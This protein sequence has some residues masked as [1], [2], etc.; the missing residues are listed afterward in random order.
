M[1]REAVKKF[2]VKTGYNLTFQKNTYKKIEVICGKQKRRRED[3]P[4]RARR[5]DEDEEPPAPNVETNEEGRT[6]MP[7]SSYVTSSCRTC[8]SVDHNKRTCPIERAKKTMNASEGQSNGEQVSVHNMSK[9]SVNSK[10][11]K[12][13]TRPAIKEQVKRAPNPR[14]AATS[15]VGASS[16]AIGSESSQPA[17]P[18]SRT[19]VNHTSS[20]QPVPN[21][22]P[23]MSPNSKFDHA[24]NWTW[25]SKSLASMKAT[26]SKTVNKD[27]KMPTGR[28]RTL[29][30]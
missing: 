9:T 11:Q 16:K 4:K 26:K 25:R 23:M 20:S 6:K 22:G 21:K 17:Q 3:R 29:W 14:R 7:R 5:R 18:I 19:F 1:F 2:A 10:V 30:K 13:S 8:G 12:P 28:A 15:T 27:P 24:T